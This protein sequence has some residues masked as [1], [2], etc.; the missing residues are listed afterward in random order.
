MSTATGPFIDISLPVSR[1]TPVFPGNPPIELG[2]QQSI[3]NGDEANVSILSLG[4]H[5]GTHL[6]APY[7][8]L[9]EGGATHELPIDATIGEAAVLDATSVEGHASGTPARRF[10]ICR[11]LESSS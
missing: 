2:L 5:T 10:C 1:E 9:P 3:A 6:D 4:V 11:C 8:F 7:H